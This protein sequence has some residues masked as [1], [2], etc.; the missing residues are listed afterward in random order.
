MHSHSSFPSISLSNLYAKDYTAT[1]NHHVRE[2]QVE[3]EATA[4]SKPLSDDSFQQTPDAEKNAPR[5]VNSAMSLHSLEERLSKSADIQITTNEGDVVT[6]SF[7]SLQESSRTAFQMDQ[8]NSEIR[9]FSEDESSE[10]GFSISVDGDLD[11]KEQKAIHELMKKMSKV[12]KEFFD[13]DMSSAFKHAQKLG[14][15][16]HQISGFSM[17][18][19][20]EQSVQAVAAYKQTSLPE[21][22]VNS[23][24][25]GQASQFISEVGDF[26][27]DSAA[28]LESMADPKQSFFDMFSGV[29]Q[30][31]SGLEGDE[32]ERAE[33]PL[34]M[35]MIKQI[36]D[37]E[38]GKEEH[39]D[40]EEM[41]DI[42][43]GIV[44]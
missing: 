1:R 29:G 14:Y 28:V 19:N 21:Q 44:Q 2:N 41:D 40:D 27:A 39:S 38:F 24:L 37:H 36:S 7:E 35:D 15:N 12:G 31:F 23:G 32:E 13:G 22:D 4:A 34:F 30:L 25:L 6:I 5:T 26:M 16:S 43:E 8:G 3:E 17:D 11:K 42:E 33:K 20:M 18:L 9:A 10:L